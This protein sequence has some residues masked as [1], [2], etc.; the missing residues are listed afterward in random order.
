MPP[1]TFG[2]Y[3][4]VFLENSSDAL[5]NM[6]AEAVAELSDS[7]PAWISLASAQQLQVQL[8]RGVRLFPG[9]QQE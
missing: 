2:F 7:D 3:Q 9:N 6:N 4:M 5:L 1:Y 8:D